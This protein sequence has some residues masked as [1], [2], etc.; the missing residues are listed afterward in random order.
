M[1]CCGVYDTMFW[2]THCRISMSMICVCLLLMTVICWSLAK[3]GE[4]KDNA[5]MPIIGNGDV[6]SLRDAHDM[7]STTHCDGVMLARAA[8]RNPW[9]FGDFITGMCV[10]CTLMIR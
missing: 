6:K 3:P 2:T 10:W 8:I 4:V 9:I 1:L 7:M 5:A